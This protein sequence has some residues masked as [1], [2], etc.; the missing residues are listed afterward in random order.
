MKKIPF[1]LLAT[2]L[3]A[4]DSVDCTLNNIVECRIGFYNREEAPLQLNDT[5]NVW[6]EGVEHP[7]LNRKNK[8]SQFAVPMSYFKD[9][10]TLQLVV[11]GPGYLIEDWIEIEKENIEH[12]ESLDCPL[13]MFHNIRSV[14]ALTHKLIDSVAIASPNVDYNNGEN[15]K[16]YLHSDM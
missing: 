14:R 9:K 11:N 15:I 2:V 6:A 13:K 16:I 8:V 5:L 10:D 7:L 12:F 4:C 1:I 3:A